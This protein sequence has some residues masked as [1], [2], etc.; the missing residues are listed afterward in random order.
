MTATLMDMIKSHACIPTSRSGKILKRPSQLVN[1]K[2]DVASLFCLG[3]GRFPCGGNTFER[4]VRL[5]KLEHLGMIADDLP[6]E[7]IAERAESVQRLFAIDSK[8]AAKRVKALLKFYGKENETP[9]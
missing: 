2:K 7:E 6:W 4:S 1:P 5:E 3:D 8:A 9:K